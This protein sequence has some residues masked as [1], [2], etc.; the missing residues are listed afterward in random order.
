ML[1]VMDSSVSVSQTSLSGDAF[2]II[3]LDGHSVC[4]SDEMG[5]F[6]LW[7]LFFKTRFGPWTMAQNGAG[8]FYQC[9]KNRIGD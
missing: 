6:C 3:P 2:S 8:G 5:L 1:L 7:A 9:F 4:G